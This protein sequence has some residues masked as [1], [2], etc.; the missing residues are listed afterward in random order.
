VLGDV[1][2]DGARAKVL[3]GNDCDDRQ[4]SVHPDA[5]ELPADG[6]DQDCD[7]KEIC[8]VDQDGDGVGTAHTVEAR[9]ITCRGSHTSARTDDCDD[10]DDTRYPGADEVP[11][12][13]VDQDCDGKELC[14]VDEDGD[15]AAGQT[16][17]QADL[18]CS[19]KDVGTRAEDCDDED[20]KTHPGAKG[21][22]DGVDRDCDGELSPRETEVTRC[23]EGKPNRTWRDRNHNGIRD[24]LEDRPEVGEVQLEAE[25]YDPVV[26]RVLSTQPLCEAWVL[27]WHHPDET[28]AKYAMTVLPSKDPTCELETPGVT[29]KHKVCKGGPRRSDELAYTWHCRMQAY[30]ASGP[31]D[32]RD[33]YVSGGRINVRN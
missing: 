33:L 10:D 29:P 24:C 6:I 9:N 2:G 19:A 27:T 20:P 25:P 11:G 21:R 30:Q 5:Q 31:R 26:F 1:D 4:A 12:D 18:A 22:A 8:Y 23:K 15:G 16:T 17:R 7:G 28:P 14:Y 13:G 3:G 32:M